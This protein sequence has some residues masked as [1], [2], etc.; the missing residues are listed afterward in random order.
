M[1]FYPTDLSFILTVTGV[2]RDVISNKRQINLAKLILYILLIFTCISIYV[3]LKSQCEIL[4]KLFKITKIIVKKHSKTEIFLPYAGPTLVVVPIVPWNH[5]IFEKDV[6]EPLDFWDL[7]LWN[8]PIFKFAT[9]GTTWF[10]LIAPT[11]LWILIFIFL[12]T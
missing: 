5:S 2:L 11:L 12:K 10:K 9:F 3:S 8:Q 6:M 1:K 7:T 4:I